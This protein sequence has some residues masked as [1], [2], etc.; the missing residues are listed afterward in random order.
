VASQRRQP[1]PATWQPGRRFERLKQQQRR[2]IRD[3]GP[4]TK[5]ALVE[6]LTMGD[7]QPSPAC[8][9]SRRAVVGSA[10]DELS[11]VT[12]ARGKRQWDVLQQ[13][14]GPATC[15]SSRRR[16]PRP[17]NPPP[18]DKSTT[19]PMPLTALECSWIARLRRKSPLGLDHKKSPKRN[20]NVC[21]PASTDPQALPNRQS[22]GILQLVPPP[23]LVLIALSSHR[24]HL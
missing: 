1:R 2:P 23:C 10:T 17:E 6:R 4:S 5:R 12:P 19:Q 24:Q 8:R 3:A 22:R 18:L 15:P 20:T 14:K 9:A 13:R 16:S 7:M 21:C 11:A